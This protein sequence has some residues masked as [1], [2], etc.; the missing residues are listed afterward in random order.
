MCDSRE[1]IRFCVQPLSGLR[2][3]IEL[4][5]IER[6]PSNG[7]SIHPCHIHGSFPE[8]IVFAIVHIWL[9]VFM[10][11]LPESYENLYTGWKRSCRFQI[12]QSICSQHNSTSML[13]SLYFICYSEK[14]YAL[15]EHNLYH[16]TFTAISVLWIVSATLAGRLSLE[17]S[18]V[19]Y[20]FTKQTQWLV[21]I[22]LGCFFLLI[23]RR[24]RSTRK[25]KFAQRPC[26]EVQFYHIILLICGH[27]CSGYRFQSE[28]L[29]C[30]CSCW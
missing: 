20:F 25:L 29:L 5:Y 30:I 26:R 11:A 22:S 19:A 21:R 27:F 3:K 1:I 24:M 6:M 8:K 16:S 9:P 23:R 14:Y 15:T 2:P 18:Y 17:K 4:W 28:Y 13:T 7:E 10:D 12:W